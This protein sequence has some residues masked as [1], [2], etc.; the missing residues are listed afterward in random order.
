MRDRISGEPHHISRQSAGASEIEREAWDFVV[1][2]ASGEATAEDLRKGKLWCARSAAHAD[3]FSRACHVWEHVSADSFQPSMRL[4]AYA[5]PAPR[6]VSRR[7]FLGGAVAASAAALFAVRPPLDLWPSYDELTADYRTGT[8]EQRKVTMADH[9]SVDMNSQTSIALQQMEPG[10]DRFELIS[11]EAMIATGQRGPHTV[12]VS[13][14]GGNAMASSAKFNIRNDGEN[15]CVTCLAGDVRVRH[16][17]Q[18]V[19]LK[20]DEQVTY[21]GAGMEAVKTANAALVTAWKEGKL[22]FHAAPLGEVVREVNRYRPGKIILTNT[23]LASRLMSANFRISNVD[24]VVSHIEKLYGAEATHLP[25][26]VV[27]LG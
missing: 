23:D 2:F 18:S 9:V 10:N 21:S 4:A 19:S 20:E 7:F 17:A 8:G 27:L 1:R 15:V 5:R 13:S 11:G 25:G 24:A 12:I 3:A 22:I 16:G 26:G 14:G 6:S